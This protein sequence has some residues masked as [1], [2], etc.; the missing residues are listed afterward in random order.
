MAALVG[1]TSNDATQ[2]KTLAGVLTPALGAAGAQFEGGVGQGP[3]VQCARPSRRVTKRCG[4]GL[5]SSWAPLSWGDCRRAGRTP[6]PDAAVTR[7]RA[8]THPLTGG[9]LVQWQGL[10]S[11]DGSWSTSRTPDR[12][13]ECAAAAPRRPASAIPRAH[14][15]A[16]PAADRCRRLRQILLP[17]PLRS[18]PSGPLDVSPGPARLAA[19]G[20]NG[21]DSTGGRPRTGWQLARRV[22]RRLPRTHSPSITWSDPRDRAAG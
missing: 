7:P 5:R 2:I 20:P 8:S 11:A 17:P 1:S 14:Q 10:P 13:A 3:G 21:R 4:F 9:R 22:Q 15:R 6:L 19:G 12:V 16:G 18:G